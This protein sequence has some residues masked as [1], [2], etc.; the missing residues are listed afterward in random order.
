MFNYQVYQ[1]NDVSM[2]DV[3]N[4]GCTL[5]QLNQAMSNAGAY[6]FGECTAPPAGMQVVA[7][8]Q[9]LGAGLTPIY[10]GIYYLRS[11]KFD[12]H[13]RLKSR[14][15]P[16]SYADKAMQHVKG[17]FHITIGCGT[18]SSEYGFNN[19][20]VAGQ[21]QMGGPNSGI[22]KHKRN[23][24]GPQ[25]EWYCDVHLGHTLLSP[26]QFD[27]VIESF[28]GL[29]P[30]SSYSK[31]YRNCCDFVYHTCA[32]QGLPTQGL[33]PY[34]R[35]RHLAQM[36]GYGGGSRMPGFRGFGTGNVIDQEMQM[37]SIR[38]FIVN[39]S[40]A[41]TGGSN[42]TILPLRSLEDSILLEAGLDVA[43]AGLV[44]KLL[45][46]SVCVWQHME[47]LSKMQYGKPESMIEAD[48]FFDHII[49]DPAARS[50]F[51]AFPAEVFEDWSE[52][53]ARF[54]DHLHGDSL[55]VSA[56]LAMSV[57]G[58]PSRQRSSHP[59]FSIEHLQSMTGA[60]TW[61]CRAAIEEAMFHLSAPHTPDNIKRA[62]AN[63]RMTPDALAKH[64]V[65]ERDLVPQ[66]SSRSLLPNVN[67]AVV[68]TVPPGAMPGSKVGFITSEGCIYFVTIPR[69]TGPGQKFTVQLSSSP[70]RQFSRSRSPERSSPFMTPLSAS[71]T[72][73]DRAPASSPVPI[74]NF[75]TPM[76]GR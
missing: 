28:A 51:I 26:G 41:S 17:T 23:S 45:M 9:D 59:K 67:V 65:T 70:Q 22:W 46:E 44:R 19:K 15:H 20:R 14:S 4:S 35:L 56:M 48:T 30:A 24:A 58:Q 60:S 47:P 72:Y 42:S 13:G 32:H 11:C 36:F 74:R 7:Q 16:L 68:I 27:E 1:N 64:I 38:F 6:L 2:E 8:A 71:P 39:F 76:S 37:G 5:G 50:R 33:H 18:G 49:A 43:L 40:Y 75:L 31:V 3:T 21:T 57:L 63:C 66:I 62:F 55:I 69:N 25:F 73:N 12:E 61:K 54:Y 52:G 34:D 10:A 53:V 29:F